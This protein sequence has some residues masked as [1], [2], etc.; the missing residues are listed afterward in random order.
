MRINFF[1]K[2]ISYLALPWPL[3]GFLLLWLVAVLSSQPVRAAAPDWHVYNTLL[4]DYVSKGQSQGIHTHL[5][6]YA[7]L[8]ADPRLQQ[9]VDVLAQVDVTGLQTRQQQLAFYINAYNLLTLNMV[10]KHWPVDSIRQ[11]GSLFRPVWSL[12][13]GRLGGQSV[14]LSD[15]EHRIL[16]PMNDPRIH[17]ALVGGAVGGPDLRREAFTAEQVDQQL[18]DQTSAFLRNPDKGLRLQGRRLRVSEIFSWFAED[19]E[20]AGGVQGFIAKY[21][22]LPGSLKREADLPYDWSLNQSAA[23]AVSAAD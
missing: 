14:T 18:E 3:R 12:P 9:A 13:A 15:I 1:L 20:D 10:V 16:R 17:F 4:A 8:A 19:F 21:R 11:I 23:D 5:V 6:D 7:G 22:L 2:S